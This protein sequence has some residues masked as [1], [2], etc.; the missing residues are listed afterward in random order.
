MKRLR[1]NRSPGFEARVAL[2]PTKRE[3]S[4][5]ARAVALIIGMFWF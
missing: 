1:R 5:N 2:E 4:L 3:V